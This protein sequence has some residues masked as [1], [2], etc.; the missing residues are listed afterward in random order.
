MLFNIDLVQSDE[1]QQPRVAVMFIHTH[2]TIKILFYT[3]K[4]LRHFE[5][6]PGLQDWFHLGSDTVS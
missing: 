6:L 3:K 1:G 2:I 5:T 4:I